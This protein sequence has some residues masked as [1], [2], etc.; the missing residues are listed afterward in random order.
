MILSN[1]T[2][3]RLSIIQYWELFAGEY[4]ESISQW[5]ESCAW[6]R[7]Y[8]KNASSITGE[9]TIGIGPLNSIVSAVYGKNVNDKLRRK[10]FNMLLSCLLAR[11][12]L[13]A[14]LVKTI[15][16]R[17][18]MASVNRNF[19]TSSNN[20]MDFLE[21]EKSLSAACAL[22]RKW[23]IDSDEKGHEKGHAIMLDEDRRD[24]DYLYGRLLA[25]ADWVERRV[26]IKQDESRETNAM[27]FKA[28][29]SQRPFDTWPKINEKLDPYLKKVSIGTKEYM[30]GLID[31]ITTDYFLPGEFE[32]NSA[33]SGAYLLGF[34]SQKQAFRDES[35]K[36]KQKSDSNNDQPKEAGKEQP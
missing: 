35:L 34:S 5:F 22:W 4:I 2:K 18:S 6:F 20:V 10:T 23:E 12:P 27:R 9:E 25:I 26:L 8:I 31:K 21:W 7:P 32:D 17:V 28:R 29:F 16:R 36:R 19:K 15:V 14:Y 1:A 11:K 24:R 30:N 3:G 33:L 13:P